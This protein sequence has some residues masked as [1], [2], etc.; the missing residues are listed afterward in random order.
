MILYPVIKGTL[1]LC[2]M[3]DSIGNAVTQFMTSR[4]L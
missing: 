1:V 3:R 4:H 2:G